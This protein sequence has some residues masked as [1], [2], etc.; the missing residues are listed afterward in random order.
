M[1]WSTVKSSLISTNY[2]YCHPPLPQSMLMLI[3]SVLD[4]AAYLT[5]TLN[6]VC[7]GGGGVD[8]VNQI[9]PYKFVFKYR[10]S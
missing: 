10:S 1:S 4:L 7:G 5:S 6:G 3:D 9:N 2:Y 8:T